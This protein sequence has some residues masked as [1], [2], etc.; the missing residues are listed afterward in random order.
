MSRTWTQAGPRGLL[1]YPSGSECGCEAQWSGRTD[2]APRLAQI[3]RHIRLP[4]IGS[5]RHPRDSLD[6]RHQLPRHGHAELIGLYARDEPL[7]NFRGA[8]AVAWSK[9][10]GW[11]KLPWATNDAISRS[12]S[13]AGAPPANK[14]YGSHAQTTAAVTSHICSYF[15]RPATFGS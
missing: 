9:C 4:H 12:S 13:S 1:A 10:T 7:A 14:L 8:S 3:L 15:F 2:V 6:T 5:S 11:V